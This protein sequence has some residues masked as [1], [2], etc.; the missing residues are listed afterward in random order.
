MDSVQLTIALIAA[1]WAGTNVVFSGAKTA[2][3]ARDKILQGN[4]GNH[5]LKKQEL[6]H[7]LWFDWMPLVCGLSAI[8]LV[9]GI[10]LLK[11]PD[12]S[13]D[14]ENLVVFRNVCRIA[15]VV[16]WAGF[17]W[18]FIRGLAEFRMLKKC[19]NTR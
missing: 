9:L 13:R 6:K 18:F 12:F 17:C 16:P 3:E 7:I 1:Y 14:T 8:S 15:A 4:I 5:Q 10:V 2:N 11:L 19:I